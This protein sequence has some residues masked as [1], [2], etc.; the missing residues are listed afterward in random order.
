MTNGN[1]EM[2]NAYHLHIAVI[3]LTIVVTALMRKI[4]QLL[5]V[6]LMSGDVGMGIVSQLRYDVM[7]IHSVLTTPM[8]TTAL[9]LVV[10]R[11]GLAVRVH[12]SHKKL[13]VMAALTVL[14]ALMRQTVP[15]KVAAARSGHVWMDIAY[16]LRITVMADMTVWM[17]QMRRTAQIH[18][19]L[20][21]SAACLMAPAFQRVL[22]AMVFKSVVMALMKRSVKKDQNLTACKP[23][24]FACAD[25]GTCIPSYLQCD[26]RPY[27]RD[28]S[29]ELNCPSCECRPCP[30][31]CPVWR[32]RCLSLTLM[33][34]KPH[35]RVHIEE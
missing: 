4:A 20:M 30:Q 8:S 13:G 32:Q 29:D 18:A 2:A 28:A 3:E 9:P 15:L 26:G 25:D 6:A 31:P 5:C 23:D 27:C 1:A 19:D 21:I 22:G 11:S 10:V 16:P 14:M 33:H 35:C 7:A 24:E 12:A 17:A 34:P